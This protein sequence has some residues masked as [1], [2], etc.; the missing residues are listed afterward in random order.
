M[1]KAGLKRHPRSDCCG[2][3][4]QVTAQRSEPRVTGNGRRVG[5][6]LA[7]QPI[8]HEVLQEEEGDCMTMFPMAIY[9]QLSGFQHEFAIVTA[10]RVRIP[11]LVALGRSQGHGRGWRRHRLWAHQLPHFLWLLRE[12]GVPWLVPAS[13]QSLLLWPHRLPLFCGGIF[14]LP[15]TGTFVITPPGPPR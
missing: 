8:T 15:L 12:A 6:N 13:L 10:Q 11:E 1:P 7:D 14:F 5:L 2:L 3:A 9:P 4:V